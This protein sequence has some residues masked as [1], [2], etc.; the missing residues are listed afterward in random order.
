[1]ARLSAKG[2][3]QAR[4]AENQGGLENALIAL[5]IVYGHTFHADALRPLALHTCI[6]AFQLATERRSLYDSPVSTLHSNIELHANLHAPRPT[7]QPRTCMNVLKLAS[8][9]IRVRRSAVGSSDPTMETRS[10]GAWDR[11]AKDSSRA[12][13]RWG[14]SP[15][16][17]YPSATQPK[18]AI[19]SCQDAQVCRG[20]RRRAG[21]VRTTLRRMHCSWGPRRSHVTARRRSSC[22]QARS[23]ENQT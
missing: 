19:L 5:P 8:A 12:R 13:S 20:C 7:P 3:P 21:C 17:A 16:Q 4:T 14:L 9:S 6:Y 11:P 23:F 22:S 1:M 2:G 10:E 18:T 15:K